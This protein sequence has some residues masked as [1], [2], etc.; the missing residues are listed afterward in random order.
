MS[1]SPISL[2]Y[3]ILQSSSTSSRRQDFTQLANALQSG[4]LQGAQQAFGSLEQLQGGQASSSSGGSFGSASSGLV[5]NGIGTTGAGS[6]TSPIANDFAALD[7]A[8]SSDE[9]SQAQS[10]FAQLQAD[11]QSA[12]QSGSSGGQTQVQGHHRH[13][14]YGAGGE[15][16]QPPSSTTSG[17][18][19]PG[20]INS[21]FV[22]LVG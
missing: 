2:S 9:L 17:S 22:N 6:S 20:P 1:I 15:V 13:H 19:Y 12:Q 3:S 21:G 4:N 5:I 8:L 14:H 10:A 11:I 18:M 7:Q 16:P